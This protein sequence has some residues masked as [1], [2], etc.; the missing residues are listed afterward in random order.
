MMSLEL[1]LKTLSKVGSIH[2][3]M[4][5]KKLSR[6]VGNF[7]LP[8]CR[9]C[10]FFGICR[11]YCYA[12]KAEK[13]PFVTCSR[14]DNFYASRRDSF[15]DEMVVRI[16]A[17]GLKVVRFQES[18]DIY[19]PEYAED[20][21][22]IARRLPDV[23]FYLYTKS[24]PYTVPLKG[25][26]NFTV[27][28]SYGGKRDYLINPQT[29]NYARVVDSAKDVQPDEHLC[30]AVT[31]ATKENQK[32][33]GRTCTHCHGEGHQVRVCFLKHMSG[34]NWKAN[35]QRPSKAN[36]TQSA[37]TVSQQVAQPDVSMAH[38]AVAPLKKEIEEAEDKATVV[39]VSMASDLDAVAPFCLSSQSRSD[40][41]KKEE[42]SETESTDWHSLVCEEIV[43]KLSHLNR[44]LE[45]RGFRTRFRVARDEFGWDV[46]VDDGGELEIVK[47]VEE[48]ENIVEELCNEVKRR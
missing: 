19:T 14:W 11:N 16:T 27:I 28:F 43:G 31:S 17:M 40:K 29:D 42:D 48:A 38:S 39:D 4:G 34:K 9:T 6:K 24:I 3:S 36:S 35:T 23:R 20:L 47:T 44:C 7:N 5:N 30:K 12:L 13:W 32:V 45:E 1:D 22:E 2:I 10:P 26:R 15:V 18:G 8:A 41:V 46:I 21:A 37:L 25:Q 33:C